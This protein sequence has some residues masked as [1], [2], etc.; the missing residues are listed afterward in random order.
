M[1]HYNKVLDIALVWSLTPIG[2]LGLFHIQCL[3]CFI[4]IAN[5]QFGLEPNTVLKQVLV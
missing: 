2:H 1:V 4:R 5:T 3:H